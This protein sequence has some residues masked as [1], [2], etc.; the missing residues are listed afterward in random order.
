VSAEGAKEDPEAGEG[1]A[2]RQGAEAL[3][4]DRVP[5]VRHAVPPMVPG[6]VTPIPIA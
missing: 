5:R 3:P 1:R 4:L 2:G 6:P